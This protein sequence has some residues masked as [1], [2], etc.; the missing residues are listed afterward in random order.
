M[1]DRL[2]DVQPVTVG[3]D[4]AG[5]QRMPGQAEPIAQRC[6]PIGQLLPQP[7]PP[8]PPPPQR[9]AARAA[10]GAGPTNRRRPRRLTG[11]R[12]SS[13]R[14]RPAARPRRRT[15]PPAAPGRFR[16]SAARRARPILEAAEERAQ[17]ADER[18][19]GR[20]PAGC[21]ATNVAIRKAKPSSTRKPTFERPREIAMTISMA[22]QGRQRPARG[23]P[24]PRGGTAFWSGAWRDQAPSPQRWLRAP[25][26]L[27]RWRPRRHQVLGLR[28]VTGAARA[29]IAGS[30]GFL[31]RRP[32]PAPRPGSRHVR[33]R[34]SRAPR[35]TRVEDRDADRL[36][37]AV[38]QEGDVEV[39]GGRSEADGPSPGAA[40]SGTRAR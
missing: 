20:R 3:E 2:D 22:R 25:R 21:V 35:S 24:Q 8:P 18:V 28:R 6:P 17:I 30:V 23:E 34:A 29:R 11:G 1:R 40:E 33:P 16:R 10:A 13:P 37:R 38:T 9:T 27:S 32:H 39:V 5:Q 15:P 36:G 31:T 7:P 26:S 14:G 12:A 4:G 19:A